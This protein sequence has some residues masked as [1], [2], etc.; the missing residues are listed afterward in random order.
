MSHFENRRWGKRILLLLH[1]LLI[2][3]SFDWRC[4]SLVFRMCRFRVHL[5]HAFTIPLSCP[6]ILSIMIAAVLKCGY[7]FF[8]ITS[9]M[10]SLCWV[11]FNYSDVLFVRWKKNNSNS[12]W[13][14]F[15]ASDFWNIFF[16]FGLITVLTFW[17]I[18]H[19]SP[20]LTSVFTIIWR[21][22]IHYFLPCRFD[23]YSLSIII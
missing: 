5:S 22:W 3:W 13:E 7:F 11:V 16:S 19:F 21:P 9:I 4:L 12:I 23:T 17:R 2:V 20:A 1:I 10:T 14:C 8:Y 15:L 18:G 6:A